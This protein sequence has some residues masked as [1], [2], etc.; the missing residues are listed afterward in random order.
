MA[1]RP[2]AAKGASLCRK[3][4]GICAGTQLLNPGTCTL[5]AAE[6]G[7]CFALYHF[8]VPGEYD[9]LVVIETDDKDV[10]AVRSHYTVL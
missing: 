3:H 6:D 4:V 8:W 1:V 10:V 7:G 9:G 5:A 2:S